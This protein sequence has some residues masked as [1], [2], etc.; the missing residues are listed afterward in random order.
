M[1][2]YTPRWFIRLQ[3][4]THP[5]TNWARCRLTSLIKPTP[6]TTTPRHHIYIVY[7]FQVQKFTT[8]R[9]TWC[10]VL[11]TF[12]LQCFGNI[13]LICAIDCLW[14]WYCLQWCKYCWLVIV[15]VQWV[16]EITHH[17]QRTPFLL[18][19][20]QVDLRDNPQQIEKLAKNRQKPI[21]YEMGEK[22]ARELKAVKYVECSALTQVGFLFINFIVKV[23]NYWFVA[24]MQFV[25]LLVACFSTWTFCTSA[26]TPHNQFRR[27][28]LVTN[29]FFVAM[30]SLCLYSTGTI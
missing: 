13:W 8:F 16:P 7:H 23:S 6:L 3:T 20:T 22:L 14:S 29:S 9:N 27:L 26:K 28:S 24:I 12:N 5:S 4:V 10:C 17:C 30:L 19:G 2:C 11:I 15:R 25:L 1:T 21:S 18:V